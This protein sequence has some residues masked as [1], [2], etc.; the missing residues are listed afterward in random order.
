MASE[1][2]PT[3]ELPHAL[4][5]ALKTCDQQCGR[6]LE[7]FTGTMTSTPRLLYH[8]TDGPGLWGILE[9]G[10]FRLTDIFK[11]NDPSEFRHGIDHACQVLAMEARRGHPAAKVFARKFLT[12]K[13][14]TTE[15]AQFF[16]GCFSCDGDELG[17]WRAYADNGRGFALEFDGA[18]LEKA[19][20]AMT[21]TS[22]T[23]STFPVFYDTGLLRGLCREL[24]RCVVPLTAMPQGRHMSA[25]AINEF[26][27]QLSIYASFHAGHSALYFKHKAYAQEK[28]YRFLQMYAAGAP[29]VDL[30]YRA[31]GSL[32]V[33]YTPFEWA[34]QFGSSLKGIII[35]P[36]ADG[37]RA[38]EFVRECLR[39]SG[40]N[41]LNI[42]IRRSRVPYRG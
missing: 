37:R 30:L 20:V 7:E 38:R 15:I 42:S 27:K 13:K 28:E 1:I 2:T 8:Y 36:A 19:F 32:F 17:Q 26:M 12:L 10:S 6:V 9:T 31:R 5:E 25:G 39:H 40:R 11:L 34:D 16:V 18:L 23:H 3:D 24:S 22:A 21:P 35:G 33:R 14:A 4:R 41:G 29:V